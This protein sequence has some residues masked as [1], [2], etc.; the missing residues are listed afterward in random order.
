[1]DDT[2]DCPACTGE[3]QYIGYGDLVR[4]KQKPAI[5]GQVV[6]EL[7]WGE[8][9]LVR[10]SS[11]FTVVW[12]YSAE[13]VRID[14]YGGNDGGGGE[15]MPAPANNVIDFNLAGMAAKGRA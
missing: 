3:D 1:M 9:F 13:L 4:L 5:T 7:N 10:L 8:Q 14:T 2:C 15:P 11:N 6:G 12:L